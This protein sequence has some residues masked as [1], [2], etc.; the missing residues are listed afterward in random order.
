VG[1]VVK[2]THSIAMSLPPVPTINPIYKSKRPFINYK[3]YY[4]K[5]LSYIKAVLFVEMR[6]KK[7]GIVNINPS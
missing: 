5:A 3:H 7:K 2:F 4:I 1:G 6:I